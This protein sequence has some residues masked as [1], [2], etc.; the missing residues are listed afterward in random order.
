MTRYWLLIVTA[1]F[2]VVMIGLERESSERLQKTRKD[3]TNVRGQLEE[4][5]M[6]A[7]FSA[8]ETKEY[9][10]IRD[11]AASMRRQIAWETDSGRLLQQMG[12]AAAQSGVR[13]TS[14]W[15]LMDAGASTVIAG[16]AFVRLKF[17]VNVTG[18]FPGMLDFFSRIERSKQPMVID[19]F[20][21]NA[22][23]DGSVRGTTRMQVSC[24]VPAAPAVAKTP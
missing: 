17:D 13:L 18:T 10:A 21:M 7:K 19:S 9:E 16:G 22:D 20:T 4:A 2:L 5:D 14:R 3:L 12:S 24:I 6:R 23:H 1:I 8:R 15:L 11:A